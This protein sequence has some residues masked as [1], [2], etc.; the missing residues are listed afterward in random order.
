M[1]TSS[2]S[3]TSLIGKGVRI[4]RSGPDKIEGTLLEARE[5][6]VVMS[7]KEGLVYVNNSHIKSITDTGRTGE[8][9]TLAK[10]IPCKTFLEVMQA[11]LFERVRINNGPEKLEGV[12]A[13]AT[14]SKLILTMKNQEIV[15]VPLFHVKSVSMIRNGSSGNRTT[16]SSQGSQ[17]QNNKTSGNRS[18][19][20]NQ[21]KRNQSGDSMP[22][23]NKS[24]YI[25]KNNH[26]S[27]GQRKK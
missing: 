26:K 4:N 17:R 21:A 10:P 27:G 11:L 1:S 16:N 22:D 8:M 2:T 23:R 19:G 15:R 6:H 20:R 9:T 7:C 25:S 3:M 12:L 24:R 14:S 13:E 5:D 18:T